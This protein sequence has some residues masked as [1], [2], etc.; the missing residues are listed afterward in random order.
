MDAQNT[1]APAAPRPAVLQTY[2]GA[3]WLVFLLTLIYASAF[4]DR[5]VMAVLGQPIKADLGLSDLSLGVLGGLTFAMFNAMLSMPVARLAEQFNRVRIIAVGTVLWSI[6][7]AACGIAASF[8]GLVLARVCVGV[9]ETV[10]PAANS[11]IADYYPHDRRASALSVYF[12]AVPVGAFVGGAGGGLIA[13]HL[14][15][16]AAFIF[17]GTPG[18]LLALLLYL[19]VSEPE[20]G[21]L[22]PSTA[23]GTVTPS[24]AAVL[25][26]MARRRSLLHIL[27]GSSLASAA[28]YGV[29][30]FL[31]P[32]FG[33]VF[34]F[35]VARAGLIAAIISSAPGVAGML[36][37]GLLTDRAVR[38]DRRYYA[39]I[40]GFTVALAAVLYIGSFL[41]SGWE[42][43][44]VMLLATGIVQYVYIPVGYAVLQNA[45]S[46][47]TRASAAAVYGLV[48]T[49]VGL[50][51]GPL[52]VGF[53]SDMFAQRVFG[54]SGNFAV[55]CRGGRMA[56][57]LCQVAAGSGLRLSCVTTTIL[58][59]WAAIHYWCA[60][61]TV[62]RDLQP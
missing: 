27:I 48:T 55:A 31:A 47:H 49:L 39:W 13:R 54:P 6:A 14:G 16:R 59:V 2:P 8:V 41:Q 12:L 3:A 56:T 36:L 4:A 62:A 37:G 18:L 33:R 34:H 19:T 60:A 61:R 24:L 11:L 51:C 43:T 1:G 46:A 21:R 58:Y 25:E 22:D 38:R 23:G 53:L 45:M 15:W 10:V 20:R 26:R 28:G 7:T 9:G 30:Y 57:G 44:T 35:D 32:Y 50:G 52:L 42:A 17:L 40:P 29:N 5:M